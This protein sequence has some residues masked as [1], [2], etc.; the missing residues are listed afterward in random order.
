MAES[1]SFMEAHE[2]RIQNL[3][4][5]L[6]ETRAN[7]RARD[8]DTEHLR[9]LIEDDMIVE[10]KA[11]QELVKRSA[12]DSAK[13]HRDLSASM[14]GLSERLLSLEGVRLASLERQRALKGRFMTGLALVATVLVTKFGEQVWSWLVGALS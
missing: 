8:V 11:T 2:R 12:E 1:L 3:E 7:E 5:Q 4:A 6:S 14:L 13:G 10:L 9:A